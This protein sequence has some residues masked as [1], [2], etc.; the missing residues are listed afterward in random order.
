[1]LPNAVIAEQDI[2]QALEH[3]EKG[4]LYYVKPIV[5]GEIKDFE[6]LEAVVRH[7]LYYQSGWSE[8]SEEN[9]IIV[10]PAL[11]PRLHREILTQ[12]MF[13]KFNVNSLF[14]TDASVASL[15]SVGK[16]G[17]IVVDIGY[18]KIGE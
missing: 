6:A 7:V 2:P 5:Q 10:E 16:T 17:G 13:E 9:V 1:M 15:Y 18:E 14:V 4:N 11:T 8:G 12:I 3:E